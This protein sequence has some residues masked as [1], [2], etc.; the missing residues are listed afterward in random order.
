MRLNRVKL[1]GFELWRKRGVEVGLIAE[2]LK[3][4]LAAAK[5]RP[6]LEAM[7]KEN[8][9]L[10]AENAELKEDLEEYIQRWGTLDSGAVKALMYLSQNERGHAGEIAQAHELNIQIVEMYL[11]VLAEGN[12]VHAP[13]NGEPHYGLARKGRRYLHERGL[14]K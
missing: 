5:Y 12:Y 13:L 6:A 14:L 11:N 8:E 1:A 4:I 2:L 9:L 7:E 10:K 3:E